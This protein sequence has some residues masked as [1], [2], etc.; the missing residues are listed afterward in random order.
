MDRAG[1]RLALRAAGL[2]DDYY[3][4]EGVHEPAPTPVDFLF[5]RRGAASGWETGLY[6]RGRFEVLA[7]FDTEEAACAHLAR[8]LTEA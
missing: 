1:L 2:A 7:R 3:W 6:E 8:L 5:L 4:I